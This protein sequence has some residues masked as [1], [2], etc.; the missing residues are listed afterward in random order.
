LLGIALCGAACAIIPPMKIKIAL[1]QF[2][3][4]KKFMQ[5]LL[6]ELF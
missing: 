6:H 2:L 1:G 4:S 5:P 3:A